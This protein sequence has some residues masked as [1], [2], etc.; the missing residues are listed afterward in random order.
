MK[1]QLIK[2]KTA[3]LAKEK[4]FFI[5]QPERYNTIGECIYTPMLKYVNN[6]LITPDRNQVYAPTQSLL[7]K[8]LREEHHIDIIVT[9]KILG[10]SYCIY[11]RYPPK[12]TTN[13]NLFEHYEEAL[14]EAL[15]ESLKLIQL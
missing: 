12:T 15:H 11:N 4:G 5:W 9:S 7:Q 1:E 13:N 6:R 3:V 8:W 14:E 2:Y 10:Y